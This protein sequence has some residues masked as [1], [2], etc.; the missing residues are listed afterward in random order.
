MVSSLV[1]DLGLVILVAC[2]IS[3]LMRLLRQ[4][5]VLGYV[6]GG[7]IIGP[8][9]FHFVKDPSEISVLSDLGIAF[10]LFIIGLELDFKKVKQVGFVFSLIGAMQVAG[11]FV[12]GFVAGLLLGFS[13]TTAFYIALGISFSSTMVVIKI[14]SDNKE[15]ESLHGELVLG[16]MLVQDVIAIFA[17]SLLPAI[18]SFQPSFIVFFLIK[19]MI[20]I[21]LII[22]INAIILPW[23][24]KQVLHNSELLFLAALSIIFFFA[25]LAHLL[26]FSEAIGAFIAGLALSASPLHLEIRHRIEPL[27]DFFLVLFFVALGMQIT[28]G[29]L[30]RIIIPIIAFI[31]IGVLV[32]G[33]I[34]FLILKLFRYGNRTSF[35]T[36]IQVAQVGEFSLV[37]VTL[38]VSLG[39]VS[40]ATGS[41]LTFITLATILLTTYLIR[42]DDKLFSLAQRFLPF[43]DLSGSREE[44]MG[45]VDRSLE[46]HVVVFGF[47][48]MSPIIVNTL[49][50][51]KKKFIVVDH[52]PEKIRKLAARRINSICGSIDN[53]EV[54]EKANLS[55]AAIVISTVSLQDKNKFLLQKLKS[56]N[57]KALAIVSASTLNEAIELY[58]AGA[59]Y[60]IVPDSLGGEKVSNY[61]EHLSPQGIRDWGKKHLAMI[62]EE[63]KEARLFRA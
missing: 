60:V 33:I 36:G 44:A 9:A 32:K 15:L 25:Y 46:G 62:H 21:L 57:P 63:L 48:K 1:F 56:M 50:K 30:D 39:H 19:I 13:A 11:T 55:K 5:L 47:H 14:L 3:L 18:G 24:M 38:G 34:T 29:N 45:R 6:I 31:I 4:P 7:I 54:Y 61:L 26:G 59:D 2:S 43:F 28:F 22:A 23:I 42:W 58:K 12:I 35:F 40:L 16:I 49:L 41:L 53:P 17:L 27:R 37:L 52:N 20:F 51:Q 8:A 10:L